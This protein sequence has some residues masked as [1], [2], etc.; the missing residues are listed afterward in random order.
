MRLIG[1]LFDREFWVARE[2]ATGVALVGGVDSFYAD[3]TAGLS[4]ARAL[5]E[6]D[7]VDGPWSHVVPVPATAKVLCAGLNYRAHAAEAAMQTPA[8][9][10]LF[11]RWARTLVAS[12]EPVPVPSGEPGLDWEGE[13]VAVVGAPL[14]DATPDEVESAILGYTCFNDLTA[15]THQKAAKQWAVGKNADR[16]G[17]LGPAVV[18]RDELT[19]PYDL[20]LRTRVDGITVQDANTSEMIFRIGQIGSFASECMTLEPG[21]LIATGTPQGVGA[22]RTPPVFLQPGQVVEVEIENIGT[23]VTP[24]VSAASSQDRGSTRPATTLSR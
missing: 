11:G 19:N 5:T 23:L 18:T 6:G 8:Y 12:N 14:R 9:P 7:V 16:S 20:R 3:I 13:L 1:V 24:I 2:L 4:R 22:A 15:R 10:D 21:D 17:P